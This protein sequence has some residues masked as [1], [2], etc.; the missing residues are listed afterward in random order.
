MFKIVGN[1]CRRCGGRSKKL[2]SSPIEFFV[3]SLCKMLKKTRTE[4]L[5]S[6]GSKE[7]TDWMAFV[8]LQDEEYYKELKAETELEN[9]KNMTQEQ[10]ADQMRAMLMG[11]NNG[12]NGRD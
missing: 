12:D 2:I 7:L 9:Q 11:L 6:M 8:A 3:Y 4:L 5:T 1:W 10:L